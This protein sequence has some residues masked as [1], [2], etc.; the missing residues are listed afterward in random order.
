MQNQIG[1]L[2]VFELIRGYT[3][4]PLGS[5]SLR[6][7]PPPEEVRGIILK[8]FSPWPGVASSRSYIS[9]CLA[10]TNTVSERRGGC[11]ELLKSRA[12]RGYNGGL[13]GLGC[14]GSKTYLCHSPALT[15][16]KSVP[17]FLIYKMRIIVYVI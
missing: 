12:Y 2:L 5:F 7:P 15:S 9:C 3:L 10:A 16:Y 1:L 6:H 11:N 4:L 13:R 17:C 14:L 8:G